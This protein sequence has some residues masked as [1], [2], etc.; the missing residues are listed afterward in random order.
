M[1][2]PDVFLLNTLD[3]MSLGLF[4]LKTTTKRSTINFPKVFLVIVSHHLGKNLESFPTKVYFERINKDF[5]EN[6]IG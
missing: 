4:S 6:L 5:K 3:K 1:G 2:T